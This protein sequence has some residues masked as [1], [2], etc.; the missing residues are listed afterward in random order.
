MTIKEFK[1][2][3]KDCKLNIVSEGETK[4]YIYC[5]DH[6]H[7]DGITTYIPY[8]FCHDKLNCAGN[9]YCNKEIACNN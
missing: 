7:V 5:L 9:G 8:P 3:H 6:V 4:V 2:V 1:E